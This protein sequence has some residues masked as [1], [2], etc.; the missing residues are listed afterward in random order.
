MLFIKKKN[1]KQPKQNDVELVAWFILLYI[2]LKSNLKCFA[3]W[4]IYFIQFLSGDFYKNH[5]L[6][7]LEE[8]A[9]VVKAPSIEF[10]KSG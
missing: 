2:Y 4:T 5:L 10:N 7:T 8:G 6:C 1:W 3:I 9:Q